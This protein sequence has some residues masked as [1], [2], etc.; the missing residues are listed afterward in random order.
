[1]LSKLYTSLSFEVRPLIVYL[2]SPV[3]SFLSFFFFIIFIFFF[4]FLSSSPSSTK[5][6]TLYFSAPTFLYSPTVFRIIPL[7]VVDLEKNLCFTIFLQSWIFTFYFLIFAY[8]LLD[9]LAPC[10]ICCVIFFT[11]YN[12]EIVSSVIAHMFSFHIVLYAVY[13]KKISVS[14][15][16][17]LLNSIL[18]FQPSIFISRPLLTFHWCDVNDD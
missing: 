14:H 18:T 3:N 5:I 6:G 12:V 8:I 11:T 2:F 4:L 7:V 1:M 15:F 16:Y 10:Y 17:F 9:G 13:L